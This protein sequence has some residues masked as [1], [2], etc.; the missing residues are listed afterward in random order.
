[1]SEQEIS[2]QNKYA[3]QNS[4]YPPAKIR[5]FTIVLGTCGIAAAFLI[6]ARLFF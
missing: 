4:S 6:V 3:E 5:W 2:Q 1:L